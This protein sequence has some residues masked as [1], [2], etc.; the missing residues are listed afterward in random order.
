M[1]FEALRPA[2]F[3]MRVFAW[4][5]KSDLY[6]FC[7]KM[8]ESIL[9][10]QAGGYIQD[11]PNCKGSHEFREKKP[12][13]PKKLIRKFHRSATNFWLCWNMAAT[14]TLK[15]LRNMISGEFRHNKIVGANLIT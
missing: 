5:G 11:T 1:T 8:R 4:C 14:D 12:K 7:A 15:N 2:N 10:I 6:E 13:G 3:I 9:A